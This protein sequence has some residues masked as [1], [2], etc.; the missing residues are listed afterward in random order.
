[1]AIW[2]NRKKEKNE[3]ALFVLFDSGLLIEEWMPDWSG[4][5]KPFTEVVGFSRLGLVFLSDSNNSQFAYLNPFNSK[6][7]QFGAA[8]SL[9]QFE[10]KYL[11]DSEFRNEYLRPDEIGQLRELKGPAAQQEVYYPSPLPKNGGTCK[12]DSYEKGDVWIL[13]ANVAHSWSVGSGKI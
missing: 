9:R 8:N 13:L 3:A 1:M 5:V 4:A 7:V 12:L 10:L 6:V 11:C 2:F